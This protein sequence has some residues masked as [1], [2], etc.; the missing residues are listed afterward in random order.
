MSNSNLLVTDFV[1]V[2]LNINDKTF[3]R[4]MFV[5]DGELVSLK[6]FGEPDLDVSKEEDTD[7]DD[8]FFLVGQEAERIL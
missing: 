3:T 2:T 7:V 6:G 8:F 4:K 5:K 1:E